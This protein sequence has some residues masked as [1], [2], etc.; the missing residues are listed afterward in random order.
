MKNL[1]LSISRSCIKSEK[2]YLCFLKVTHKRDTK[3]NEKLL[4]NKTTEYIQR[5][6]WFYPLSHELGGLPSSRKEL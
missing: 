6:Y 3:R 1:K 2:G 4:K 5:S